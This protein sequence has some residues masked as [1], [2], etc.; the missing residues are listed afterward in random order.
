VTKA[1]AIRDIERGNAKYAEAS[2]IVV[3]GRSGKHLRAELDRMKR[4]NLDEFPS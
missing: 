3:N 1:Q 4:N 2:V